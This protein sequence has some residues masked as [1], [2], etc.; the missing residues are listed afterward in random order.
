MLKVDS[1]SDIGVNQINSQR[2]CKR[3]N[4]VY[5]CV[6]GTL[7]TH[8]LD[9][10]EIDESGAEL[11]KNG[12]RLIPDS[13]PVLTIAQVVTN[14]GVTEMIYGNSNKTYTFPPTITTICQDAFFAKYDLVSV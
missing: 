6:D 4:N 5:T 13:S 12:I 8:R 9:V 3:N 7:I 10:A 1:T 2:A 11:P 14:R